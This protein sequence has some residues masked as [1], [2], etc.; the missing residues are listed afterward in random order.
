MV[1]P[2]R[3][4]GIPNKLTTDAKNAILMAFDKIGG[5]DKLTAWAL[6]EKSVMISDLDD[7][8][9]TIYRKE[10]TQPNLATFYTQ[11]FPKVLPLTMQGQVNVDVRTVNDPIEELLASYV[12]RV[13]AANTSRTIQGDVVGT[14]AGTARTSEPEMVLLGS[15]GSKAA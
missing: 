15:S 12:S 4:A 9:K 8:G 11:V 14:D 5:V 7:K 2:G 10:I 13:A 3:P 1:R 6:E